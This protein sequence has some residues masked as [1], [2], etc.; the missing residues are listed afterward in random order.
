AV[1]LGGRAAELEVFA[2]FSSGAADDLARATEI[3]RDMVVRHGM[4]EGIGPVTI[5]PPQA[6]MLEV[7]PM[8]PTRPPVS[9]ALQQ[10]VDEAIRAIVT[11]GLEQARGVLKRHRDLLE[12]GAQELLQK[13]TL[14]EAA[15]GKYAEAIR[16][17]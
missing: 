9:E 2:E 7:A 5:E 4:D 12:R 15:I 6:T 10:R 13:E 3:A 8:V 1:L 16:A 17:A 11:A 14:D